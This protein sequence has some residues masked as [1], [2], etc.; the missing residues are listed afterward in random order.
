MI[1]LVGHLCHKP[2]VKTME[3]YHVA[4]DKLYNALPDCR[5]CVCMA[6]ERAV[7]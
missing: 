1:Y 6:I 7:G 5:N 4:Y 3:A 2:E